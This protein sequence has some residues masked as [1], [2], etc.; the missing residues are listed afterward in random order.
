MHCCSAQHLNIHANLQLMSAIDDHRQ[1]KEL[2][3]LGFGS[4]ACSMLYLPTTLD[5]TARTVMVGFADGVVR[6][7]LMCSDAWKVTAT[8]KPHSGAIS[9]LVPNDGAQLQS[10]LFSAAP[11]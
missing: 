6:A 5:S 3:K 4:P 10:L 11:P 9:M 7:L 8:F 2:Y 1:K